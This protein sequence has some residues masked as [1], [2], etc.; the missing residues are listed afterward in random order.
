MWTGSGSSPEVRRE[1]LA[2]Q[3]LPP[4]PSCATHGSLTTTTTLV[5]SAIKGK[6]GGLG[7]DGL[8]GG[9]LVAL[10]ILVSA[11]SLYPALCSHGIRTPT[12]D[13]EV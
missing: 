12:P 11:P 3:D 13:L 5:L 9:L 1:D 4:P 2:L 10:F 8:L 6:V 7:H